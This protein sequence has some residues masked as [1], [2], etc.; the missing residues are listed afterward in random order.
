MRIRMVYWPGLLLLA[1]CGLFAQKLGNAVYHWQDDQGVSHYSRQPPL[2]RAAVQINTATGMSNSERDAIQQQLLTDP[3]KLP[4][5]GAGD[6]KQLCQGLETDKNNYYMS[7]IEDNFRTA[8]QACDILYVDAGDQAA[9]QNCY[10]AA[11]AQYQS[12]IKNFV[13]VQ[14]CR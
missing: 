11:T 10:D 13:P 7:R 2:D 4:A 5:T 9:R 14:Y 8:K 1:S 3:D 12:R 6:A